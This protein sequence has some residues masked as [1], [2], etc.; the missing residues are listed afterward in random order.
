MFPP[1]ECIDD[2]SR[3][4]ALLS[5][6]WV[7]N[8]DRK[9]FE[10]LWD[11]RTAWLPIETQPVLDFFQCVPEFGYGRSALTHACREL[12]ALCLGELYAL[13]FS[14]MGATLC[15]LYRYW[16]LEKCTQSFRA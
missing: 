16:P 9:Y 1:G 2:S 6:L 7:V 5:V 11:G 15:H 3:P 10:Y 12:L 13:D 4:N 14:H 8:I